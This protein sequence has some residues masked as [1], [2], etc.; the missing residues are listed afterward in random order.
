[1][2]KKYKKIKAWVVA[3]KETKKEL[4][5]ITREIPIGKDVLVRVDRKDGL[6]V[7][8][9]KEKDEMKTTMEG[10]ITIILIIIAVAVVLALVVSGAFHSK[11]EWECIEWT[12]LPELNKTDCWDLPRND[13]VQSLSQDWILCFNG[14]NTTV[15][16]ATYIGDIYL[17]ARKVCDV[18]L[19]DIPE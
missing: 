11:T 8:I 4:C 3:K 6:L 17:P 18:W 14:R 15:K 10:S 5:E 7:K 12:D 16:D 13:S 19:Y 9:I 1:M 2:K